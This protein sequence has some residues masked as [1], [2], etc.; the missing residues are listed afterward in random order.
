M[1]I[2]S[3]N[4]RVRTPIV[5]QPHCRRFP[6]S[7]PHFSHTRGPF[8]LIALIAGFLLIL[9]QGEKSVVLPPVEFRTESCALSMIQ[10]PDGGFVLVGKI[11]QAGDDYG[12]DFLWLVKTDA[13]GEAEWNKTFGYLNGEYGISATSVIQAT[14]G[15]YA[16]AGGLIPLTPMVDGQ[17]FILKTNTYGWPQ[18]FQDYGM[19]GASAL[20]QTVDGGFALAGPDVNWE[21]DIRQED[22]WLLKT[23]TT[24]QFQWS[25]EITY[26]WYLDHGIRASSL[27]QTTDGGY[28]LTGEPGRDADSDFWLVKITAKGSGQ[29]EQTYG[30]S[31]YDRARSVIQTM[32]GGF[33]LTGDIDPY[34]A[35]PYDD[36]SFPTDMCLVK[37]NATGTAQWNQTFRG[38]YHNE[39][40][41]R[42][43][44]GTKTAA[45]VST[46]DGGF[47]L[48]GHSWRGYGGILP[49]IWLIKTDVNGVVQWNQTYGEPEERL[50]AVHALVSTVDGGFALAGS[51]NREMWLLKTDA[52]GDIQWNQTYGNPVGVI[53]LSPKTWVTPKTNPTP[54]FEVPITVSRIIVTFLMGGLIVVILIVGI[55]T[56]KT[57]RLWNG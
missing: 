12:P 15:G 30:G 47:A 16:L 14:N 35:D 17:S 45:L 2:G 1:T 38:F 11:Y 43:N 8:I 55:I 13:N 50:A 31:G 5:F 39:D 42:G 3:R 25:R 57:R 23:D 40:P 37:T 34:G 22:I 54:L 52:N 29:W 24:G 56:L 20:I 49:N 6:P 27:I 48:A 28:A 46:T 32:D 53:M 33:V 51:Y 21:R 18:W 10:T 36:R 41:P 7:Q 19:D 44:D 4:L 9:P 26:P